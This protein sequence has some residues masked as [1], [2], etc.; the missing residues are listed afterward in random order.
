MVKPNKSLGQHFLNDESVILEISELIKQSFMGERIL[1][2]GPGMGAL[3]KYIIKDFPEILQCVEL[4]Q[5][6]VN[7]L[8]V[9][10][11]NLAGRI[12]MGD[13]LQMPNKMMFEQQT[14]LVGN[15]PYNISSQIIFKA[16]EN[17]ENIPVVVGM[18]QKEVA[19]RFAAKPGNKTYGVTSVLTQLYY[20][21]AIAFHISPDKFDPPP[22]VMS[23]IIVLKRKTN[24][25]TADFKKLKTVVKG[26]FSQ[27]RKKMRNALSG[28]FSPEVLEEPIFQK[29][30]EELS[31]EDFLILSERL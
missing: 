21:V 30:A 7:D 3:T 8:L 31:L 14:T 13:F 5:R 15:F 9:K 11:P 16:I 25:P 20:D 28:I 24:I 12:L 6:C 29:R 23:S 4:D 27:R 19:E 22:K 2:I 17:Y 10:F 1:E 26:A 18:F